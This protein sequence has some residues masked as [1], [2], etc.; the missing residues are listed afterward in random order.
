MNAKASWSR[1]AILL[2]LMTSKDK[3]PRLESLEDESMLASQP[4]SNSIL[5]TESRT[6][7]SCP[8]TPHKSNF[9]S[10]PA[11][12]RLQIYGLLLDG[13]PECC[14][15]QRSELGPSY[16]T[17]KLYPAILAVNRSIAAEAY[18]I[19]YG[20]NIFLFLGTTTLGL[21]L[22]TRSQFLS[23]RAGLP[24]LRKP[25]LLPER[26][27][28]LIK[29]VVAAPLELGRHGWVGQ[30]L[31]LAPNVKVVE[32]DFWIGYPL[33]PH[34]L[35]PSKSIRALGASIPAIKSLINASTQTFRI[36]T[37]DIK[38]YHDSEIQFSRGHRVQPPG[39]QLA[40]VDLKGVDDVQEKSCM[41]HK[42]L[43][44]I[45]EI[46]GQQPLLPNRT[47]PVDQDLVPVGKRLLV[48]RDFAGFWCSDGFTVQAECR[49]WSPFD[50]DG[51]KV[52]IG[53]QCKN[54]TWR[55][56]TTG[57]GPKMTDVQLHHRRVLRPNP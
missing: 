38:S 46:L 53:Q 5:Q 45:T 29:H 56:S 50:M 33:M 41:V 8:S 9:E 57:Y 1:N 17:P 11:E 42:A 21:H 19:L 36:G 24:R 47:I 51:K 23:Q 13:K 43:T 48:H 12:L 44:F 37:R 32:F 10:I 27:R 55:R 31:E 25:P 40:G 26:S 7:S 30:L 3:V 6:G 49:G 15:F 39:T 28:Q 14:H 20:E 18:P 22:D 16:S 52:E 2:A 4:I 34:Q 54:I 35:N